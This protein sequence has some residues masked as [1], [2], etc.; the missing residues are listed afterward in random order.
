[1]NDTTNLKELLAKYSKVVNLNAGDQLYDY[2]SKANR[3]YFILS[4]L[5]RVF[6]KDGNKEIEIKRLKNGDFAGESSFASD[7]Y[8]SRAEVYFDTKMLEFKVSNLRKIMK[9][10]NDF[11]NKMI[12]NLASYIIKLENKKEIKLKD[13]KEIDKNTNQVAFKIK[14]RSNFYLS[15]HNNSYN[16]QMDKKDEYFLYDKEIECPV[17]GKKISIK[18]IRNS[19]LRIKKIRKDLRPL[20]KD[21]NPYNYSVVSCPNC[22]FTARRKDLYDFSKNQKKKIKKNFKELV[23]KEISRDFTIKYDNH[24]SI[25]QVFDAHYLAIKLYNYIDY[26]TDKKAFLWRELSWIY[27]D[28]KENKL[29]NKASNK[30]LSNLEKF[31]FKEDTKGNNRTKK[32]NDNITLLLAVLYYKHHQSDKSLIL[33]DDL[34]RDNKVSLRQRNRARDLF[35][36][37]R[38]KNK[39][40]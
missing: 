1:M 3:I 19:R 30:A 25:N 28:L 11:A 35:F 38:Q 9:K 21:F 29:A 6:I 39:E 27:E 31:Y 37:I 33:L 34:I 2:Q 32:E 8:N 24:R 12:D 26:Y 17:C 15:G 5:V 10:D 16:R 13:I 7:K 40:K 20:Y 22:L 36:E 23:S 4:G 14:K 18:K